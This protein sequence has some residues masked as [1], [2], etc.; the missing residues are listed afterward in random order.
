MVTLHFK[1]AQEV[2]FFS[3][4]LQARSKASQH[5]GTVP[6]KK[7]VKKLVHDLL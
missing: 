6:V 3:R 5:C 2:E 7:E 4:R 1:P